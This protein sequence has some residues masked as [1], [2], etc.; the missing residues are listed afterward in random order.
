MITNIKIPN[1]VEIEKAIG[2]RSEEEEERAGV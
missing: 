2:S 1:R